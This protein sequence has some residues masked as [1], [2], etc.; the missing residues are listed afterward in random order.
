MN[1]VLL[2][3]ADG[4]LGRLVVQVKPGNI[5]LHSCTRKNLDI[6]DRD[7][8][9]AVI[10]QISPDIIINTAAYTAV[11]NAEKDK[12]TAF[13]VNAEA[14]E[15]IAKS[16]NKK[17]RI[18]HIST[19]FVFSRTNNRLYT[20][21]D[22]T[23]PVSVYGESKLAGEK[24]LLAHHPDNSIIIRTSWLYS[25]FSKN[26]LTTM[27]MLMGSRDELN[28]VSDQ[29]GSPTSAIS[30]ARIIWKFAAIESAQGLFHWSDRG[31]IT[32]YDFAVEIQKQA[33]K[34][35]I[36]HSDTRV[37]PIPTTSFP[38]LATRP[39]YSALDSSK[40]EGLLGQSTAP[41]QDQLLQ[42][43]TEIKKANLN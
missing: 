28:V 20:P 39:E 15:N 41:W 38:T 25:P 3:G 1:K 27:L 26:F 19:D 9:K 33:R 18:I 8:V 35:G 34:L 40:T 5:N 4:Q 11:D 10:E 16:A 36:L 37:N 7:A 6:T 12:K 24:A 32:W 23:S 21:E 31:V 42:V 22:I 43:L 17:I 29:Y 2:I 30:L 14:V 13:L